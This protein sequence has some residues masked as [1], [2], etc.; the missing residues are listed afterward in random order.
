MIAK[1]LAT[2]NSMDTHKSEDNSRQGRADGSA[3]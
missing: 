2:L 1:R 3:D